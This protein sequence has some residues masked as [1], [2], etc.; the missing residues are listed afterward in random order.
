MFS[1]EGWTFYYTECSTEWNTS[2]VEK[3]MSC[4]IT[5]VKRNLFWW[6]NWIYSPYLLFS[7]FNR[8]FIRERIFTEK[9][10]L[11]KIPL[12]SLPC[13]S[14]SQNWWTKCPV[15]PNLQPQRAKWPESAELMLYADPE[16]WDLSYSYGMA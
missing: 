9:R 11:Q 16:H 3:E 13:M 15:S 14:A 6:W 12:V 2:K 10:W 8:V 4:C 7:W 5:F 1:S